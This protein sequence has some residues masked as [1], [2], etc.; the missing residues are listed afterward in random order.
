[1]EAHLEAI[2]IDMKYIKLILAAIFLL[3]LADMPYGFYMLVRFLS[4]VV[5]TLYA[6]KYYQYGKQNI[7]IV[8]IVLALLFQPFA[9]IK[10]GRMLWNIVDVIVALFLC[11]LWL[12]ENK[13]F[14][15]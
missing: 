2:D 15:T 3:C 4:M 10:L 6:I 1:M 9:M 12:K 14:R 8:F 13:K 5:F 11:I 7:S